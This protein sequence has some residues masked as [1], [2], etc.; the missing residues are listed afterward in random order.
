MAYEHDTYAQ[1][2]YSTDRNASYYQDQAPTDYPYE[3]KNTGPNEHFNL[4]EGAYSYPDLHALGQQGKQTRAQKKEQRKA[5]DAHFKQLRKDGSL[6]KL[7]KEMKVE[8]RKEYK[9]CRRWKREEAGRRKEE[10][11]RQ[12]EGGR[13][14]ERR[15]KD[16]GRRK[17][18]G[19]VVM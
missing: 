15:K 4:Q 12:K 16:G 7:S 1:D 5:R 11:R 14:G 6:P 8:A 10:G 13:K 2:I 18:G 17:E 3:P 9:E 19:C